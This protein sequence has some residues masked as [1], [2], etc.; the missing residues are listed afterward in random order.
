MT[1]SKWLG[2]DVSMDKLDISEFDGGQHKMH[3]IANN[4]RAIS[5]FFKKFLSAS[6]HVVM[7]A[8]GIYHMVLFTK[9]LE[10]GISVSVV[11]PLIIKR[12]SQMKMVRAK[13]DIVDA[14]VI[15]EF[16]FEQN[17]KLSKL[18]SEDQRKIITRLRAINGMHK[19]INMLSNKIHALDSSG[20]GDKLVIKEYKLLIKAHRRS[21]KK[22]E[23]QISKLVK[24]SYNEV[25]ERVIK[26]PGVGPRTASMTIGFFGEFEDFESAKQVVSFVG[27]NPNPRESG[28][29]VKRGSNISKKGNPLFRKILYVAA[30]SASQYNPS[31]KD[32]YERLS[33][34]GKSKMKSRVAVAHKL[35]RQIFAVVKYE[36]EWCP[37]YYEKRDTFN[38]DD[39][40]LAKSAAN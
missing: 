21:I 20:N 29:S 23:E 24:E 28:K 2:V 25:Y 27:L 22:F 40:K 7:E 18:P 32:L 9:L 17:P 39:G 13:T 14:R 33:N 19:I 4:K 12:F 8:T 38:S 3:E 10:L 5:K 15:A 34:K 1:Y 35:L 36:R 37:N 30:L 11:N 26:I 31:C 16:G 6:T